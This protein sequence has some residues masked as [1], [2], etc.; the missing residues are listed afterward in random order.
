M[1]E[2]GR[3]D[4][5]FSYLG[6]EQRDG[7]SVYHLRA[8]RTPKDELAFVS[9]LVRRLSTTD[10][11]LDSVSLLPRALTFNVHS[12]NDSN[13]NIRTEIR[14][15]DYRVADGVKVPFHIQQLVND[16]LVLDLHVTSATIN[17]GLLES[18]FS[19]Q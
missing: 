8:Y 14:F 19:I 1:T 3:P 18:E 9:S 16:G 12:D 7:L 4:M 5:I 15:A 10:I 11:Y 13:T 6:L 2:A 17:S